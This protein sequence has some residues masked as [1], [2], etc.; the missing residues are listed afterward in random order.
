MKKEKLAS[1]PRRREEWNKLSSFSTT[2][3][4]GLGSKNHSHIILFMYKTS[5]IY[6][7]KGAAKQPPK[8]PFKSIKGKRKDKRL[9]KFYPKTDP[10]QLAF[11]TKQQPKTAQETGRRS[12]GKPSQEA[13]ETQ[14]R[15]HKNTA[16]TGP[17]EPAKKWV[18]GITGK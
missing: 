17:K 1:F 10:K 16:K 18:E 14:P 9:S 8:T 15:S 11:I 6:M 7:I 5:Y 3:P 2:K 12:H 13:M 4:T